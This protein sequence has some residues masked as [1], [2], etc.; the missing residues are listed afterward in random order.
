M[1][2]EEL[3]K[4]QGPHKA[5][6]SLSSKQLSGNGPAG[7]ARDLERPAMLLAG[8]ILSALA[9]PRIQT[10]TRFL[11]IR[12]GAFDEPV[13]HFEKRF[14]GGPVAEPKPESF[15]PTPSR[16]S[17]I[18]FA[19][20][21]EF[22]LRKIL[23]RNQYSRSRL[24]HLEYSCSPNPLKSGAS[25]PGELIRIGANQLD[26][27]MQVHADLPNEQRSL[28]HRHTVQRI[29]AGVAE[30]YVVLANK[31]PVGTFSLMACGPNNEPVQE[32]C[33]FDFR[34]VPAYRNR[35]WG[36]RMLTAAIHRARN[37]GAM[38]IST[39]SDRAHRDF[40]RSSGF[41][42][43]TRVEQWTRADTDLP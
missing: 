2:G 15:P 6:G 13:Y 17:V 25:F 18:F 21:P 40:Y 38:R 24:W 16:A 9:K 35:G 30:C 5:T 33:L 31:N 26:D 12:C 39:F 29:N 4:S 32:F 7:F 1:N 34:I 23:D 37:H 28:M 3:R 42:I 36:R 43:V 14:A 27:F 20:E 11:C 41:G 22:R 19:K 8:W 10:E